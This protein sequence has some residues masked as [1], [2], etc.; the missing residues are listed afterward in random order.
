M[1]EEKKDELSFEEQEKHY[2]EQVDKRIEEVKSMQ[3]IDFKYEI[4][5]G[6]YLVEFNL[7]KKIM[8]QKR[9]LTIWQNWRNMPTDP[10]FE[11]AFYKAV[12][13]LIYVN[14]TKLKLDETELEF[15]VVDAIM[16]AYG[17]F[18][19]RPFSARAT[20]KTNCHL[21]QL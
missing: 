10:D 20:M 2:L 19:M 6:E 12:E 15:G 14:G 8:E 11:M 16:T 18:M 21:S 5:L 13:S 3:T 7:P 4:R 1:S 9:L 17:D